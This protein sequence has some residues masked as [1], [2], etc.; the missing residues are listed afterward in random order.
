MAR[1]GHSQPRQGGGGAGR[2]RVT[3]H[4]RSGHRARAREGAAVNAVLLLMGLLVLSYIGSFLVT[5]RSVG[6]TGLPSGIEYTALGYLLGPHALGLIGPDDL[7]AF[8]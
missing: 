8:E 4:R 6:S 3:R 2:R 5:R 7:K 1:V